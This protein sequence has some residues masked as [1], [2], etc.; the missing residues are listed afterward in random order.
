MEPVSPNRARV[1]AGD[2]LARAMAQV[3]KIQQLAEHCPDAEGLDRARRILTGETTLE[4][5]LI[6][7]DAQYPTDG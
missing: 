4:A 3:E 1:R 2:D 5:A 6:E 7:I